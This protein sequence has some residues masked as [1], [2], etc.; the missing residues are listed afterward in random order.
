MARRLSVLFISMTFIL[1]SGAGIG[2][3]ATALAD[4]SYASC[5]TFSQ[6]KAD[7]EAVSGTSTITFL[8]PNCSVTANT[9]ILIPAGANLT[10]KGNGFTL[11]GGTPASPGA[12]N[13]ITATL[14]GGSLSLDEATLEFAEFAIVQGGTQPTA[15]NVSNSTI[16]GN[17][18]GGI[19]ASAPV[20]VS[21]SAVLQN[22]YTGILSFGPVT[23]INSTIM[24]NATGVFAQNATVTS[25]TIVGNNQGVAAITTATVTASILSGNGGLNCGSTVSDQGY[26]LSSDNTCGF[27]AAGSRNNVDPSELRLGSLADNGGPTQTIPPMSNSVALDAIP[28]TQGTCQA[29]ATLDQRGIFRPAGQ[30]CDIGAFEVLTS[31]PGTS[32]SAFARAD[33]RVTAFVVAVR[34][35]GAPL[36]SLSYADAHVTLTN[37]RLLSL[38]AIGLVATVVGTAVLSDGTPVG[39]RLEAR[40]D[41]P[42]KTVRLTLSNGYESGDGKLLFVRIVPLPASSRQ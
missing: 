33:P 41:Y 35:T 42:T 13:L 29:G 20:T 22:G 28:T 11:R 14:G 2:L 31:T 19:Q 15:I 23:L 4:T 32:L 5:P 25:S 3:P 16:R 40:A 10:I 6:F 27:S 7:V 36:G 1:A 26:N 8:A 39:F 24:G 37:V 17:V 9:T 38:N 34:S 12:F 18:F 30:G 21:G